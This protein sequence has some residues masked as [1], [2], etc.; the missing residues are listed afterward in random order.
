[1]K[2]GNRNKEQKCSRMREIR[3][4]KQ[5]RDA[6][7]D[8]ERDTER[9]RDRERNTER[10]REERKCNYFHNEFFSVNE[11]QQIMKNFL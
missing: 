3:K 10:E 8:R 5:E 6:E 1:M 11:K 2:L 7:R 4:I 9:A